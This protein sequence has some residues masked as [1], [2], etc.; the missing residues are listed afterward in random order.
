MPFKK[1]CLMWDEHKS[2]RRYLGVNVEQRDLP[3]ARDL[4]DRRLGGRIAKRRMHFEPETD[5]SG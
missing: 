4:R 2:R 1:S 3:V 5:L